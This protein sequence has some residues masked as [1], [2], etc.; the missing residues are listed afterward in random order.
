MSAELNRRN[1]VKKTVLASAGAGL[2]AQVGQQAASAEAPATQTSAPAKTATAGAMPIGSIGDM[3]ISRLLLGGNLLTHYTHSRDLKYVYALATHYNTPEKILETLATAEQNGLNT[4]VVHNVPS[5]IALLQEH[6][7]RGGKI[8]WITCTFH[9]LVG[10]MARFNREIEQLVDAG[11]DA[12]YVSGVEADTVC[13]FR[14]PTWGEHAGDRTNPADLDLLGKAVDLAKAHGL[15]T[16]LGAHRLGPIQDC[17]K[18][19][20]DVDFYLKTFHSHDYPSAKIDYDSSFCPD[21]EKVAEFMKS[22]TKPWIAYK[23]MAA[24]AIPPDKAFRH[25]WD[26]GADFVLAGMFDFEIEEDARLI[27]ETFPGSQRQR[28]LRA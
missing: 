11:T 6:R 2:A 4:L 10:G 18:A 14:N 25:A 3:K 13:G 15:P 16:G 1:F 17:E 27:R 20:I 22:V 8:Q 21:P 28:P 5:T 23:V 19:G 9:A 7:R 24:G 26:H 12:L